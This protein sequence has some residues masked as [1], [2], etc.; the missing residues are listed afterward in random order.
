MMR[1][2]ASCIVAIV[3]APR[4]LLELASYDELV[5]RPSVCPSM[6]QQQQT[7]CCRFAAVG[8][9]GRR[10]LSIAAAAAGECGQCH[11]VGVRR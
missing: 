2:L 8:P 6:G 10:H 11:V 4:N 1:P 3:T 7:R 9:A 5:R